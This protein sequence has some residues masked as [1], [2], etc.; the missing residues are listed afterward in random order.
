MIFNKLAD[1]SPQ[2]SIFSSQRSLVGPAC[3]KVSTLN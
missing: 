1:A 2:L 3:Y